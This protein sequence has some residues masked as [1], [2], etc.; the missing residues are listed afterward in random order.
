MR[1]YLFLFIT[2]LSFIGNSQDA[3][4]GIRS[5]EQSNGVSTT[6]S[7]YYEFGYNL[8]FDI[9][10]AYDRHLL[11]LRANIG[12]EVDILS[13]ALN[14]YFNLSFIYGRE[15]AINDWL[16]LE[17]FTGIGYVNFSKENVDTNW[18]REEHRALNF[19]VA[20]KTLFLNGKV[21]SMGLNTAIDFNLFQV[22]YTTNLTFQFKFR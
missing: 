17:G 1:K 20:F 13:S 16:V 10:A 6:L 2:T 5:I 15:F 7:N 14:Q 19:P 3:R 9:S 18:L 11:A 22:L 21:F 12:G 4:F 8:G